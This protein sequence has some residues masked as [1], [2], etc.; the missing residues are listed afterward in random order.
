MQ[1]QGSKTKWHF[2]ISIV[3]SLTRIGAGAALLIG[4]IPQAGGLLIL[5]E[6]FGI[7]EEL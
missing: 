5:A 4:D 3:K 7:V 1:E 2:I 6:V